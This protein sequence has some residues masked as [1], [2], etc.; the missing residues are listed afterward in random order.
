M[1]LPYARCQASLIVRA[2][3]SQ[4]CA[5]RT[6]LQNSI[7]H[8]STTGLLRG[9]ETIA[10]PSTT[11]IVGIVPCRSFCKLSERRGV[12]KC[13]TLL[14]SIALLLLALYTCLSIRQL[15]GSNVRTTILITSISVATQILFLSIKGEYLRSA[16]MVKA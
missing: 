1:P 6:E 10:E 7:W 8:Y 2:L 14:K 15:G 5:C 11:S 13:D 9:V 3:R 4:G 12:A 16:R